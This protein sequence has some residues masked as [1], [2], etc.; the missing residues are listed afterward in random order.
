MKDKLEQKIQKD[1]MDYLRSIGA[2]P[3]K[4]NQIGIYSEKGVPDILACY[5]GY[6]VAIEV[7]IPGEKPTKIQQRFLGT[8]HKA[9]GQAICATSVSDVKILMDS[10]YNIIYLKEYAEDE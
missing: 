7:K 1:I 10:L 2:L 6:F 9:G 5:G 4:Q 3:F 8:I